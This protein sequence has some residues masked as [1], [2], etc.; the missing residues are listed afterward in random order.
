MQSHVKNGWP[1]TT[2]TIEFD[3]VDVELTGL[4]R[5]KIPVLSLLSPFADRRL[6]RQPNFK[7]SNPFRPKRDLP[8]LMYTKIPDEI[9]RQDRF[10]L[11]RK[12]HWTGN[13][14]T[15]DPIKVVL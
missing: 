7:K 3:G 9:V 8:V 14:R 6:V 2:S 12:R 5:S 10:W 15:Y 11:A 1:D 4:E 13:R